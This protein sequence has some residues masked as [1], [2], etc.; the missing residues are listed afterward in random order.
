M[1]KNIQRAE[2][3]Y[4]EKWSQVVFLWVSWQKQWSSK[5]LEMLLFGKF[6]SAEV[7]MESVHTLILL[8][9]NKNRKQ[10]KTCGLHI[11][12]VSILA[13]ENSKFTL[14]DRKKK[15]LYSFQI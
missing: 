1:F 7:K 9:S 13:M 12:S 10:V 8:Y 5:G 3:L 11:F 4:N 2:L 15:D 14:P 6:K